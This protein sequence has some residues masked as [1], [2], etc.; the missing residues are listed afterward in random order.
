MNLRH[1]R[2]TNN[3]KDYKDYKYTVTFATI[4][5][6]YSN[7]LAEEL[8]VPEQLLLHRRDF[9]PVLVVASHPHVRLLQPAL[10]PRHLLGRDP[11]LLQSPSSVQLSSVPPVTS[12]RRENNWVCK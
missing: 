6:L 11:R 8:G 12:E 3:Y 1:G 4:V 7:R 9:Q 5:E 10:A 2:R